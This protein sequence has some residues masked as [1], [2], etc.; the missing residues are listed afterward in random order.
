MSTRIANTAMAKNTNHIPTFTIFLTG[1]F[2]TIF[3]NV[4]IIVLILRKRQLRHIRFYIIANLAVAD[5]I[6]LLMLASIVIRGIF[7]NYHIPLDTKVNTPFIVPRVIGLASRITSLLTL[8]FLAFD[9][10]IAV[11]YSLKYQAILTK[12]RL[13]VVLV[14][15]WLFSLTISGVNWIDVSIHFEHHRNLFITLTVIRVIISVL[16]I[17]LSK[18]T[19]MLRK[20]HIN[21]I[22]TQ[23]KCFGI[24]KEKLDILKSL[25]R[26]LEDSC[27]LYIATVLVLI[28]AT[29]TGIVE[30]ASS[31]VYHEIQLVMIM[32]LHVV[33]VIVLA[34]SQNDIRKALKYKQ[35]INRVSPI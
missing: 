29:I 7:Q 34:L 4:V 1:C 6:T 12:K 35:N 32:L 16:L 27:K 21:N 31:E 2:I 28:A 9:R 13:V 3:A 24:A 5:I 14:V 23:K 11:E 18:Y 17:A 20:K 19:K 10:Y 30:M 26:S 15:I 8:V 22:V 25:K 33:D